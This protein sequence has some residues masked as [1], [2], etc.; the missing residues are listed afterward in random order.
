MKF[1]SLRLEVAITAD[2]AS[3]E[4]MT[5]TSV[6][7]RIAKRPDLSSDPGQALYY[8]PEHTPTRRMA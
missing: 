7:T 4:R 3:G 1:S 6:P 2:D 5:P 8:R